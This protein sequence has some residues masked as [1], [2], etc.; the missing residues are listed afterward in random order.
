[1]FGRNNYTPPPMPPQAPQQQPQQTPQTPPQQEPMP[2]ANQTKTDKGP[3]ISPFALITWILLIGSVFVMAAIMNMGI[4]MVVTV[5]YVFLSL[6]AVFGGFLFLVAIKTNGI[7]ELKA[8]LYGKPLVIVRRKDGKV[9]TCLGNYGQGTID[10]RKYGRYFVSPDS[11]QQDKK[12]GASLIHVI[13]SVGTALTEPF[14]K[15]INV[16]RDKFGL[17][18]IDQIEWA[19]ANWSKCARCGAEG[20]PTLKIKKE[21]TKTDGEEKLVDAEHEQCINCGELDE[22]DRIEFPKLK[23]PLYESLDYNIMDEYFKYNQN[24]DRLNV[25]IKREV[26]NELEKEKAFPVKWV[27]LIFT[28]GMAGFLILLGASIFVP[29]IMKA[30]AENGA[31]V[32]PMI[33]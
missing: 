32:A 29:Q 20:V 27:A 22:M 6:G 1:M 14:I 8:F 21:K 15:A 31:A 4:N 11:V 9:E 28:M 13:D 24:P 19:R 26:K 30:M 12:S 7:T 3:L 16:L 5:G 33:G 23:L 2:Q 25:I 10:L 18:D 17:K